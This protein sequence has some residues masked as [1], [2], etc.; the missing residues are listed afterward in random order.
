MKDLLIL[1]FCTL[2]A[3]VG[4]IGAGC[5]DDDSGSDSDSDGDSDSDSDS[6]L[7]CPGGGVELHGLCWYLG[8]FGTTCVKACEDNGGYAEAAAEYVGV[9]AQGGS[10]AECAEIFD[11]LGYPQEVVEGQRDDDLGLGCHRWQDGVLW[12]LWDNPF[13][14]EHWAGGAQIVCGCNGLP[15]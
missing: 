11:A 8:D 9:E 13:N 6:D 2:M 4:A 3:A 15:G 5:G 12:W 14:P 10:Q 7:V 1:A